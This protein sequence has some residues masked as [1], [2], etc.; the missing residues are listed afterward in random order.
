MVWYKQQE[1]RV[2]VM[3]RGRNNQKW[4]RLLS[5]VLCVIMLQTP[6]TSAMSVFAVSP[7]IME[8]TSVALPEKL[9]DDTSTKVS[10][11]EESSYW[12]GIASQATAKIR[13]PITSI[14]N[15]SSVMLDSPIV[16][17]YETKQTSSYIRVNTDWARFDMG[18]QDLMF[19][20][21]LPVTGTGSTSIRMSHIC[22][23][24]WSKYPAPAGMTFHYLE[25]NGTSWV[26]GTISTDGNKQIT[27]PDG[28]KGYIRIEVNTA[29]NCESYATSAIQIQEFGFRI[30]TYGAEYGAAKLGGVWF[31]SKGEAY[32]V[33]VD[34]EGETALTTADPLPEPQKDALVATTPNHEYGEVGTTSLWV[35]M[36]ED[37]NW[38]GHPS[39]NTITAG[40]PITLIG[41]H[42]SVVIDS[43]IEEGYASSTTK[44]APVFSV[45]MA[46][47]NFNFGEQDMMLY[48]ELPETGTGSSSIRMGGITMGGW[49]FWPDPAGMTF[50]YLPVDGSAWVTSTISAEGNKQI[51]LPDGF[52]GYIRLQ[53]NTASNIGDKANA[54]LQLQEFTFNIGCFGGEYG[55]A[56]LGGVWFVSKDEYTNISVDGAST[57]KMTTYVEKPPVMEA[58]SVSREPD[59]WNTKVSFTED[60]WKTIDSQATITLSDAITK[61]SD[62]ASVVIDSEIPEGYSN[63][64]TTTWPLFRITTSAT[65]DAANQ[66]I[67]FYVELPETMESLRIQDITCS[68]WSFWLAPA[69]MS[70]KYLSMDSNEWVSGTITADDNKQLVLPQGFKG[71]VRL[72]LNTASN[73]ASLGDSAS[74]LY[75]DAF[76]FRAQCFGGDIGAIKIGGVWFVSQTDAVMVSVDG[77]AAVKMTDAEEE[78]T[79]RDYLT[80]TVSAQEG[81]EVGAASSLITIDNDPAWAGITSQAT[82]KAAEG[83]TPIGEQK[84][85]VIDSPI[86]EGYFN[87]S[88]KTYPNFALNCG[89]GSLN[90]A[91]QDIMFYIELPAAGSEIR[92]GGITCNGWSFWAAPAGMQYQYLAVDGD[93]WVDGTITTEGN[94]TLALPQG[95]KGYVRLRVNTADNAASF[96]DTT[97]TVQNFTFTCD[98]FG[99]D[100]GALKISGVWF[101]SKEDYIK[102]QVGEGEVVNMTAGSTPVDPPAEDHDYTVG[103]M[104]VYEHGA[105]GSA[106]QWVTMSEDPKWW[107]N[108]SQNTITAGEPITLIGTQNSVVIDS[109]IEEGYFSSTTKTAPVFC[110]G[111]AWSNFNFA[112]QDLM[113]Y[114]ELPATG[115]GSSSIRMGGITMG[116]WSFWPDPAGMTF[117]Y[118]P[119]DG[120]AWVT[121]TISAEGNKQINLPDGFKGYI[122][123]QLNTASNI[124]DKANATLQLQEFTFNIGCFGGEYGPAKLGGVWFV[125]KDEYI[126][127]QVD[128]GE[129][130]KMTTNSAPVE[131]D[132]DEPGTD[133]PDPDDRDYTIGSMPSYEQGEIGGSATQADMQQDDNWWGIPTQ[134]TITAG[135]PITIIGD[136]KSVIFDSPIAEG[137]INHTAPMFRVY[138]SWRDF[139]FAEQD[140]MF[141]MEL[142][143][144]GTGA[145]SI[146]IC[147]I[148]M[149]DWSFWPSPAGM[150]YQYLSVDSKEWVTGVADGNKQINLPDGFKGYIRLKLNTAENIG[151]KAN[152]TLQLQ[153]FT[154]NIGSFGGDVGPAK[155][156][157]VWFVSKDAFTKIRV[158]GGTVVDMTTYFESNEQLLTSFRELLATLDKKDLTAAPVVDELNALYSNMSAEYQNKVSQEDL[159]T[160]NAYAAAIDPYR[161]TFLGLSIMKPGTKPQAIK[162]GWTFDQALME[163]EG[164][165]VVS[166]G[167]AMLNERLYDGL[168][169]I[170]LNTEG[171]VALEGHIADGYCYAV[172]EIAEED[173]KYNMLLRCYTVFENIETGAQYTVWCGGYTDQNSETTQFMRCNMLELANYFGVP[174][175]MK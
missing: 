35:S 20:V 78:Q 116:G 33:S 87:E 159:D 55:P 48:L 162:V 111:M 160:I 24:S 126:K 38:W 7:E 26:D 3:N 98:R 14:D 152:A 80:A 91:T 62:R 158:D 153:E 59:Y 4:K 146:R 127:I 129:V 119:V 150:T 137:Y 37:P 70:Y 41:T 93:E 25:T 113:L 121:S 99:G 156:G 106:S 11:V 21:E 79:Q 47:A 132:P 75:V 22:A 107:G 69:G 5:L 144:T 65:I 97:L 36:S 109:P 51:N 42:N 163:R 118:L 46:W 171:V 85:V 28:F 143:T 135:N 72:P 139:K 74:T 110:V 23:D 174:L 52:K 175:Y 58:T 131:P 102:I 39:Q 154:F 114:M 17:G 173:Y 16:E 161:P 95:F 164:Y 12:W 44:T 45:G 120:S 29:G 136:Q 172:T 96:P 108:P 103:S 140:L 6:V 157:G 125:S 149:G 86:G 67:M 83:I 82:M 32:L 89:W 43:P 165:R 122:R 124:G 104:P 66:D 60:S 71:Y 148:T 63:G 167:V 105:V 13:E 49:S 84:S 57:V 88:G 9:A 92:I 133:E 40:N 50:Q 101:V 100:N 94:K 123:L 170:D 145:S 117:Q 130:L 138:T 151:D 76:H 15:R 61:I 31:V 155:L 18:K 73:F 56:K 77:A 1:E 68:G 81:A 53:L 8:A 168:S 112:E 27:L 30:G 115:T 90:T 54:T 142:P 19:Y 134:N 169:V 147:G 2:I 34:G 166:C 128:D 64:G 10:I 141:Y